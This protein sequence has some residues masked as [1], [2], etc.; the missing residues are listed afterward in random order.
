MSP[1]LDLLLSH[2]RHELAELVQ[3]VTPGEAPACPR[4]EELL[5]AEAGEVAGWLP[6]ERAMEVRR[7]ASRLRF[8]EQ[9]AGERSVR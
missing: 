4:G 3:R 8:Y 1:S 2:Y 7:V 9:R 6:L 5:W